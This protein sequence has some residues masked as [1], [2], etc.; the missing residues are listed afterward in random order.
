[1]GGIIFLILV[2]G[3]IQ[4]WAIKKSKITIVELEVMAELVT[5]S[6]DS[7]NPAQRQTTDVMSNTKA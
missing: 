5:D 3:T 1:M 6:V 7:Q 4:P 2:S